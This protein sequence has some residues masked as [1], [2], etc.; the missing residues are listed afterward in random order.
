MTQSRGKLVAGNWKMNMLH[1]DGL[2]LARELAHRAV[3]AS[4]PPAEHLVCELLICPPA[5]LLAVLGEAL[6]GSS[7]RLGGQDCHAAA[8]G[9][10]TG[11]ISAEMLKDAGC[12]HVIVGH[13]ER[14][15]DHGESDAAVRA[16]AEAARRA[17]LIAIICVGE[18]EAERVAGQALEVVARQ[19]AGS[20]PPGISAADLVVAYEPVWAIGTGRT[21]TAQDVGEMHGHIRRRLA[22]SVADAAA[23]R[24]LYGGSV[25]PSNAGELLAVA[26]VD[27]A[28]VGGASLI[29]EDFW[30]IARSCG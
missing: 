21:P 28:L 5:T 16:K 6:A 30:A 24:L 4:R 14:R 20:I 15:S 19:L 10:H 17:G 13:S 9:A 27:G 18:S 2:T 11:D 23:V 25:K 8:K 7:I 3:A 26:D 29:A 12:S 22:D 1:E